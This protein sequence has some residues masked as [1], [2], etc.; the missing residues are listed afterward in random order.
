M[1]TVNINKTPSEQLIAKA[2]Q[3]V[4]VTD[5]KGRKI[6]LRKPGVLAQFRLVEALGD[7]AKNQTYVGMVLPLIF[8]ASIDGVFVP[9][10]EKKAHVEALISRLDDDGIS[11]VMEA[12]QGNFAAADPEAAKEELKN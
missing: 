7:S 9:P 2:S 1:T 5:A 3:E 12:V 11:A 10:L 6:L 8:V 4:E